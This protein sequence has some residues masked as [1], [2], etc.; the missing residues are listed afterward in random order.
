MAGSIIVLD[1][2]T[3]LWW[4]QEAHLLSDQA[5]AVLEEAAVVGI[6]A[7]VFWEI[8]LLARNESVALSGRLTAGEWSELVLSIPRV[9]DLPLTARIAVQ[10]DALR[11]H[12]D[13]ADRFIVSTAMHHEA[14]IVT[15][16]ELLHD[17]AGV[18][19]VW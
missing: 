12:R 5:S 16:D 18:R 4:T 3:L 17:R 19:T 11:M 9:R 8:S 14:P 15:R 10:A 13:A 2:H 6:P 7:V 1:T